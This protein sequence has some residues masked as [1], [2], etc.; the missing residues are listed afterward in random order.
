[1]KKE[2]YLQ[3]CS[4]IYLCLFSPSLEDYFYNAEDIFI[5]LD[6]I[7]LKDNEYQE[8][9]R[10]I[11]KVSKIL[12]LFLIFPKILQILIIIQRLIFNK[13]LS[14]INASNSNYYQF[15]QKISNALAD[16]KDSH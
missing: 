1:M 7:R 5:Y 15:Y 12:M 13:R 16:L 3:I 9:L 2:I 11:S 10:N 6:D 14:E 4:L 8:V